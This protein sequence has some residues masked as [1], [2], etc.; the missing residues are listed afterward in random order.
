MLASFTIHATGALIDRLALAGFLIKETVG[1]VVQTR[2]YPAF[3][4][5]H[6]VKPVFPVE[7]DPSDDDD[8]TSGSDDD[9]TSDT[10]ATSSADGSSTSGS[11]DSD[12]PDLAAEANDDSSS[13]SDEDTVH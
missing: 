13:G 2:I 11:S 10:E 9:L 4:A 5:L 3:A 6:L 7:P 12:V 8:K 1:T